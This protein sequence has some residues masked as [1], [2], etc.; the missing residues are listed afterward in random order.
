MS[1][2]QVIGL[3]IQ[4]SLAAIV[5]SVGMETNRGDILSLL[6]RPGLLLRSILAMNIVMP[7]IAALLVAVFHLDPP[8]E[9]ALIALAVSPVPPVLPG[10]QIKAGASPAYA[11]GLL[12][13]AAIAAIVLVPLSIEVLGRVFGRDV[14]VPVRVVVKAVALSVLLP[15]VAGALV[16]RIAPGFAARVSPVL[17]KLAT[18]LLV[19]A[20]IPALVV[21]WPELRALIGNFTLVAIVGI[22]VAGI[23]VGHIL[24]GP[25]EG[26]RTALALS[27]ASRHPGVAVAVAHAISPGDKSV[28]MAVLLAFLVAAIATAPYAK[29][30]RRAYL[31][32]REGASQ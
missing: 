9:I 7:V 21:A 4:V 20:F 30:R 23:L 19:A 8:V 5:F 31:E 14:N 6:R 26:D 29:W 32:A 25:H 3:A 17:S 15:L 18:V 24:G 13:A 11:V 16:R 28:V 10:K 12:A 22:V 2:V 1:V 27:T